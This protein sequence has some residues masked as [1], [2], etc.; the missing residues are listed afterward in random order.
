MNVPKINYQLQ[1]H[2]HLK[3]IVSDVDV[4]VPDIPF[5]ELQPS[6]VF[7]QRLLHVS[8]RLLTDNFF[9]VHS[10][11]ATVPIAFWHVPVE[12]P[13]KM[14]TASQRILNEPTLDSHCFDIQVWSSTS[15]QVAVSASPTIK[16]TNAKII[17][18]FMT[19]QKLMLFWAAILTVVVCSLD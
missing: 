19:I 10:H 15:G 1:L 9:P 2:L 12:P 6:H 11:C 18:V 8:S 5:L 17:M 13:A 14:R 16:I 4:H 7:L 3:P